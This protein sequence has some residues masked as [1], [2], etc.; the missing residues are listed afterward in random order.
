[1]VYVSDRI[2]G[3]IYDR[4]GQ[5]GESGEYQMRKVRVV[6]FHIRNSEDGSPH[7]CRLRTNRL[8]QVSK[9]DYVLMHM[10]FMGSHKLNSFNG[11]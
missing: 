11:R 8:A 5:L 3:S 10:R 6:C 9:I 7:L 4:V 1:V 2:Y